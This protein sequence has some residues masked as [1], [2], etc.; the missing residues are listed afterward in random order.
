MAS[1]I[2][3][4]WMVHLEMI[5]LFLRGLGPWRFLTVKLVLY[6]LSQSVLTPFSIYLKNKT[7]QKINNFKTGQTSSAGL[8]A[9]GKRKR[10]KTECSFLIIDMRAVA[11]CKYYLWSFKI[12]PKNQKSNQV[13]GQRKSGGEWSKLFLLRFLAFVSVF[14]VPGTWPETVKGNGMF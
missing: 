9:R 10:I 11:L 3:D 13:W 8:G 5:V 6:C 12:S 2:H 4:F 1:L 14:P 7:K